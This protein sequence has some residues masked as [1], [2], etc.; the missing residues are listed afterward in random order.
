MGGDK[1]RERLG[2]VFPP[3]PTPFVNDEV[4]YDK[5]AE[6]IGRWNGT[7]IK[8]YVV[9]GSNG[10]FPYLTAD[11]KTRII[12]T[13]VEAAKPAGKVIIAGVSSESARG[14]I[15]QA[16][17]AA[18]LGADFAM[19]LTPN[20]YKSKM[21]HDALVAYYTAVADASPIPVLVYSMP[22]YAGITIQ[23]QT[24]AKLSEHPNIAGMKDSGG[25]LPLTGAY[26]EKSAPDFCVIAGSAS[27]LYPGIAVGCKG[28]ILALANVLPEECCRLYDLAMKG[29][30]EEA[31]ELQLKL[32]EPN[33]AVT[34]G[35]GIAGLK[36]AM[37]L[38]G[39]FGGDVRLPLLPVE[40]D[41]KRDI[42]KIFKGF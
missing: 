5:L 39:Y 8:G 12:E 26:I 1:N 22:A 15:V 6:N 20:Y 30:R 11:E 27:F 37:E 28:G 18:K 4:A 31:Q 13:V 16:K 29:K 36:Y 34:A 38:K 7:L 23:P 9:L 41:A 3:I 19:A 25:V 33:K 40:E 2:G 32:L 14:T 35:Y 42:E 17:Q 10:E 21:T 24:I